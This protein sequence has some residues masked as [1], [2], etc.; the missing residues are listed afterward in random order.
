MIT[1]KDEA[2]GTYAIEEDYQGIKVLGSDGKVR[3][4]AGGLN[5]ALQYIARALVL[6]SDKVYSLKEYS[7]KLKEIS[8]AIVN[9][10]EVGEVSN[11]TNMTKVEA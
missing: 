3:I 8:G 4:K 9:A 11:N 6:D 1:I 7:E 5:E 10:Q 2:L